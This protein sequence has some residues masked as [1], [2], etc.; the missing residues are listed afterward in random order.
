MSPNSA[1]VLVRNTDNGT[2]SVP[3]TSAYEN[4]DHLQALLGN[5]PSHIPGIPAGSSAVRELSTSAGPI[6][7]CV[8]TDS[9]D[10][11]VV[12]C[13]LARNSERRRMVVGQVIDYASAIRSDGPRAFREQWAK[14]Q[15]T[16][17]DEFLDPTASEDLEENIRQGRMNLCLAVDQIDPDLRRLVEYLNLVTSGDIMVSALQLAYARHGDTEILIPSTYGT[18][19]AATAATRNQPTEHWTWETFIEFLEDPSDQ[20][21]ATETLK[22]LQQ[23]APTGNHKQI[24]F[25]LR[26]RGSV[27]IKPHG[28]RYG[29]FYFWLNSAGQLKI[30]G[31]WRM[32]KSVDPQHFE[33]LAAFLGQSHLEGAKG[34]LASDIDL[35][36]FWEVALDC[37]QRIQAEVEIESSS[38]YPKGTAIL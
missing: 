25:G 9:G 33:D 5:D 31:S 1:S 6:D 35:D 13:K 28:N 14:R 18:E 32:W 11:T 3:E 7:I 12:E 19:L 10:I 30:Y 37:D 27:L 2:W 34:V 16:D 21:F 29:P 38:D 20:H 36:A 24:W 4:E 26:P 22:R 17:L 8:V 23:V 15:G